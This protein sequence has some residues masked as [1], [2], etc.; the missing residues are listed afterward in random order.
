MTHRT[1]LV[2]QSGGATA[3]INATLAGVI[4]AAQ[5]SGSFDRIMGMRFGL[6]GMLDESFV[7]LT[8]LCE[9]TLRSLRNTPS[10]ALGT[11]R[12]KLS[13]DQVELVLAVMRRLGSNAMVL[14]GGNDSA[15]TALRLHEAAQVEDRDVSIMLAPKTVD[16]DLLETDY[17]PGYPSAA[18]CF[19]NLVRDV[20]YDSLASPA[21]YPVKFVDVTGRDAGWLAAAGGLAFGDDEADLRPLIVFP[22]RPPDSAEALLE[23]IDIAYRERGWLVCILPETLRDRQ[24]RHLGGGSPTYVDPFGHPYQMPPATSM[25]ALCSSRLG[26]NARFERPGSMV[27]MSMAMASPVDLDDSFMAGQVAAELVAEGES[28]R[29]VTIQRDDGPEYRATMS[30]C[31]LALVANRVRRLDDQFIASDGR[32]TTA[33]F[34]HYALPL[35]GAGPFGAYWR[36]GNGGL[37]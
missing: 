19:A 8:C 34:R 21:L 12:L 32:A 31:S 26:I 24:G 10:S 2:G 22:E 6:Q 37:A 4:S 29:M 16:N 36:L 17:C 28:G 7:D 27:R 9:R 14:I 1:L 23:E 18:R 20:T 30:S 5:Q 35:L 11:S 15:D 3:T 25:A 13:S 33:A